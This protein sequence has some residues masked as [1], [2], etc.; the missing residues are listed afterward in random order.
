MTTETETDL[1]NVVMFPA[2]GADPMDSVGFI[3]E[4]AE[5][6]LHPGILVSEQQRKL[7]CK[8][9]GAVLDAFDYLLAIA[10]RETTLAGNV[11]ALRDEEKYRRESIAKLIVIERNAKA[12]IRR[13]QRS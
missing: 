2:K 3:Y 9:C 13:T 1:A 6:C 11:K 4:R 7:T 5:L 8:K 12:R 10:K